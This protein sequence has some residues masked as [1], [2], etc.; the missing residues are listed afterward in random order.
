MI[1][2]IFLLV[3]AAAICNATMDVSMFHYHKS[4]FTR[5]NN[6]KWWNG[7]HSWRNKYNGGNPEWGRNDKPIWFTDAFHFFKS[8]MIVC[9][10]LAITLSLGTCAY[11]NWWGKLIV[12]GMLGLTWNLTFNVFYH[13]ILRHYDEAE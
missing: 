5:F 11:Y 10:C 13:H 9:L 6:A 2:I 1:F 8:G 3:A 12:F 7:E 4:I